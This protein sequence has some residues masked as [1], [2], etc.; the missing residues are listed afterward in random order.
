MNIQ[1]LRKGYSMIENIK[2]LEELIQMIKR[3]GVKSFSD[4]STGLAFEFFSETKKDNNDLSFA[5]DSVKEKQKDCYFGGISK[6]DR[7]FI[8]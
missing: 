6:E 2:E 5:S 3:N 8:Q 4:V 1:L 7:E